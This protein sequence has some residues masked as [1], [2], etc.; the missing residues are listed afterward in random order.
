MQKMRAA[1]IALGR[2]AYIGVNY[3]F[4]LLSKMD[5]LPRFNFV[6]AHALNGHHASVYVGDYVAGA[7][8]KDADVANLSARVGVEGRVIEHDLAFFAGFQF[9]NTLAVFYDRDYFAI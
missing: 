8:A 3:G 1:V 2:L 4:D 5:R 9:G 7:I 6:R